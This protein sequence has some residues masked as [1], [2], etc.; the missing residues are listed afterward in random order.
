MVTVG[1]TS[2]A[3]HHRLDLQVQVQCDTKSP[4][5]WPVLHPS[6]SC[7]SSSWCGLSFF[8][9]LQLLELAD[10]NGMGFV[11]SFGIGINLFGPLLFSPSQVETS[12]PQQLPGRNGRELLVMLKSI[13]CYLLMVNTSVSL[14]TC[15]SVTLTSTLLTMEKMAVL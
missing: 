13:I 3:R 10:C 6:H 8:L 11:S 12:E 9:S 1:T 2:F 15:T 4:T 5:V 7:H 14:L